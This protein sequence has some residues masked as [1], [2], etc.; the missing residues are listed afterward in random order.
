LGGA[1]DKDKVAASWLLDTSEKPDTEVEDYLRD[2][3]QESIRESKDELPQA[4]IPEKERESGLNQPEGSKQNCS[5]NYFTSSTDFSF[6]NGSAYMPYNNCYNFA[7]NRRTNSFAYPGRYS[8]HP[9]SG[10]PDC[11]KVANAIVYDGW[12][13]NCQYRDNLSICLVIWAGYDFHFYRKCSNGIWCHKPGQTAARN[14]DNSNR[15]IT[16]PETCNR[17]SYTQ[18]CGYWYVDRSVIQVK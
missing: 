14:Y 11:S 1:Y 2:I 7:S 6:W 12:R 17:G 15:Q 16:N 4:E 18:F 10:E 9:F 3:V 8:G 5:S 13:N